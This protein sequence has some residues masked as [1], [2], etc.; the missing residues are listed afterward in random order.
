MWFGKQKFDVSNEAS[1]CEKNKS[2][3]F[4]YQLQEI[5]AFNPHVPNVFLVKSIQCKKLAQNALQFTYQNLKSCKPN[6]KIKQK[7]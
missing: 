2:E 7:T 1:D 5:Y 4:F 6:E 3:T